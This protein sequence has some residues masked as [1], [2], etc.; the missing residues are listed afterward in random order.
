[1]FDALSFGEIDGQHAELL[2][3]RTV[4]TVRGSRGGGA[5]RGG[6][7]GVGGDGGTGRAVSA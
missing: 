7:G 6:N 5:G 3:A 2:P 1:M 4:L